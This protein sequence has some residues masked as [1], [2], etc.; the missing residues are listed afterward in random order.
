MTK[1]DG[2]DLDATFIRKLGRIND[3]FL[4]VRSVQKC[5][6]KFVGAEQYQ[7]QSS[8]PCSDRRCCTAKLAKN[9]DPAGATARSDYGGMRAKQYSL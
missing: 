4:R 5:R 2:H 3:F 6:Y 7:E 1:L 9:I 8:R